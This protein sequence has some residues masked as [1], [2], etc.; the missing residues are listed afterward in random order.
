MSDPIYLFKAKDT[1]KRG[2]KFELIKLSSSSWS[3]F[4]GIKTE[5]L[6]KKKKKSPLLVKTLEK[7]MD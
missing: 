4:I 7:S 1:R 2:I 6:Q 3:L 5:V